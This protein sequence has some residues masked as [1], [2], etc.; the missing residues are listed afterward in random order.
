[1][2]L[3]VPSLSGR[4]VHLGVCQSTRESRGSVMMDFRSGV[5]THRRS[6][7]IMQEVT[8]CPKRSI[9]QHK[10]KQSPSRVW[11]SGLFEDVV[12]LPAFS[13][14]R[15]LISQVFLK[16]LAVVHEK[17]VVNFHFGLQS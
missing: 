9:K 15:H 1:M 13:A 6:R 11:S 4:S 10:C 8:R 3:R 2:R 12:K 5:K 16:K 14:R 17:S 7:D